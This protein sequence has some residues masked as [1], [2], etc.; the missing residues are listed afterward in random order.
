M[1][2]QS[3][4]RK[5]YITDVNFEYHFSVQTQYIKIKS[6]L[7]CNNNELSKKK[8]IRKNITFIRAQK[9]SKEPT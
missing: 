7:K 8:E 6:F 9:Y 3:Q 2:L 4:K 5:Q 1:H